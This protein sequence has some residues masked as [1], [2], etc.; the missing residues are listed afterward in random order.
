MDPIVTY[1]RD[2]TF[3]ENP[4]EAR[5]VKVRSSRFTILNDELYKRGFS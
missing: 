3:P 1:I 5:K 4:L 2:G